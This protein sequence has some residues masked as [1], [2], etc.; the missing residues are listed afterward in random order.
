VLFEENKKSVKPNQKDTCNGY[1]RSFK[2]NSILKKG[3][4]NTLPE[5]MTQGK[6]EV[7]IQITKK[8]QR[9]FCFFGLFLPKKVLAQEKGRRGIRRKGVSKRGQ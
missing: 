3:K 6:M 5:K 4:R 2:S 9:G 8:Q 7:P 1:R